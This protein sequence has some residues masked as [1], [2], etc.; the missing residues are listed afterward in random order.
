MRRNRSQK[1]KCGCGIF[2]GSNFPRDY[3]NVPGLKQPDAP[4]GRDLLQVTNSMV[5]PR[6]GG[7][8]PSI[9]EPFVSAASKYV[10][11]VALFAGYKLMGMG[12]KTAKKTHRKRMTKRRR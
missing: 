5:R 6:I 12:K 3:F 2:G 8:I 7:F 4:A 9:G 1:S 10:A 11:P